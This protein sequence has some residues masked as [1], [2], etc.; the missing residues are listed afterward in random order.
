MFLNKLNILNKLLNKRKTKAFRYVDDKKIESI[1]K[2]FIPKGMN[3]IKLLRIGDDNDGGYLIPNILDE[4][5]F[6]FSAGVG[7]TN[8]FETDLNKL[9]IK[10]FLADYSVE[11]FTRDINEFEFIK[12]YIS[13]FDSE[14]TK[15]I[16]SWLKENI[17]IRDLNKAILKLDVEGSEYEIMSS[18]EEDL[19]KEIRIVIIEFHNLE[20]LCEEN[21]YQIINSIKQK[22]LKHFYVAHIHP[23]NC[24]GI[25]EVSKFKVPSVL[26]VTYLNKKNIKLENKNCKIPNDLDRKNVLKKDE[27]YLPEYWY[28]NS[29]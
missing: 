21:T 23:N 6:C 28:K 24:C 16:N 20:M 25:H 14:K 1:I 7:H 3:D 2:Y 18:L 9:N 29:F 22:I 13:S 10:S 5:K 15:N 4:I 27:I 8:K 19:L 12:K 17:E 26:E 11:K